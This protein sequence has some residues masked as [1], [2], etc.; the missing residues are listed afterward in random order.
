[1]GRGSLQN[2]SVMTVIEKEECFL[3]SPILAKTQESCHAGCIH[4]R[5]ALPP[6]PPLRSV[7]FPQTT[8][9]TE[10]VPHLCIWSSEMSAGRDLKNTQSGSLCLHLR[11]CDSWMKGREVK[12]SVSQVFIWDM[13]PASRNLCNY[14]LHFRDK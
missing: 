13:S 2:M 6:P 10:S 12:P 3:L 5:A 7:S 11:H 14:Y 9:P 1:M 8:H 4:T